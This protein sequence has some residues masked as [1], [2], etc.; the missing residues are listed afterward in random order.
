MISA[1]VSIL[2]RYL[3]AGHFGSGSMSPKVEA[4]LEFIKSGGPKAVITSLAAITEAVTGAAGT[5]ITA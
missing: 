1:P 2:G 5:V 3:A 4:A